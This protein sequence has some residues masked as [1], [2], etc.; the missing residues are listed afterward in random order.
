MKKSQSVGTNTER[1]VTRSVASQTG[2]HLDETFVVKTPEKSASKR[3][4]RSTDKHETANKSPRINKTFQIKTPTASEIQ[5]HPSA[6][7]RNDMSTINEVTSPLIHMMESIHNTPNEMSSQISMEQH[8]DSNQPLTSKQA[9][10]KSAPAKTPTKKRNQ[11]SPNDSKQ[12][13]GHDLPKKR[14]TQAS[15]SR[16]SPKS[17]AKPYV[18]ETNDFRF[19]LSDISL[20]SSPITPEVHNSPSLREHLNLTSDNEVEQ[21]HL[22]I[23]DQMDDLAMKTP[24]N[25]TKRKSSM[26]DVSSSAKKA[27]QQVIIDT[28]EEQSEHQTTQQSYTN[29]ITLNMTPLNESHRPRLRRS[30]RLR[31]KRIRLGL[32]EPSPFRVNSRHITK[33]R[34]NSGYEKQQQQIRRQR[35]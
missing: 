4:S 7:S 27:R 6:S 11:S 2:R 35:G 29:D 19:H 9:R 13:P 14:S 3:A 8:S 33:R 10:A 18:N 5:I 32:P 12:T 16:K 21:T 26:R 17:A 22:N 1:S 23:T 34:N 31:L 30:E 20:S 25:N 24:V 15:S 28:S